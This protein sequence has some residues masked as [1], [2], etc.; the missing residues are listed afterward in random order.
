M[1][2]RVKTWK[3]AVTISSLITVLATAV[4]VIVVGIALWSVPLALKWIALVISGAIPLLITFPISMFA[5]YILKTLH[6]AVDRLDDLIKFDS[7]TGLMVRAHFLDEARKH[8]NE[9]GFIALLDA[10]QFKKINDT[11][12]HDVGDSALRHLASTMLEVFASHG[13]VAR[14]GG[15]EFALRLPRLHRK[16]AE[17]LF[18]MLGTKLRTKGFEHMGHILTPTL[19]IGVAVVDGERSI[20]ESLRVADAC[21]Y[22]AKNSGRDKFVF[23]ELDERRTL[24]A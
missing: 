14:F 2:L 17:L 23:E 3:L 13:F 6:E 10:D 24:T 15:E 11:Y 16:E 22:R 12:G 8:R 5:M 20:T 1:N 18:A 19:S 7:L 4:P 9:Q 21:L